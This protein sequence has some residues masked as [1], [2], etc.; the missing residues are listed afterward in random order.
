[1]AGGF[2]AIGALFLHHAGRRTGGLDKA[3][4]EV[5]NLVGPAKAR[6][7]VHKD[8]YL[9]S[10]GEES[11]LH[12]MGEIRLM[13]A[14]FQ[15]ALGLALRAARDRKLTA[16]THVRRFRRVRSPERR[17][18]LEALL[19]LLSDETDFYGFLNVTEA[20]GLEAQTIRERIYKLLGMSE[21]E[22][23]F[24][25]RTEATH[26]VKSQPGPGRPRVRR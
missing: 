16:A 6:E 11:P 26:L 18:T 25:L 10:L 20:I 13:C 24:F 2:E 7:R 15:D 3:I 19:W 14:L 23:H 21:E 12:K 17:E 9:A 4:A 5:E 8:E 1:V 22:T